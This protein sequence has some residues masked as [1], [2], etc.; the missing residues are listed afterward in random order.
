MDGIDGLICGSMIIIF[1]TLDGGFYNLSPLIGTLTAFLY[2]N[3][4]PSKI[5]M[6]DAGSLF[7]GSYLVSL[8]YSSSN[9]FTSFLKSFYYVHLFYW[10]LLVVFSGDL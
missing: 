2:F 1:S 4:Y 10:M 9:D 7:L 6:G 8:M 5:F 3:W